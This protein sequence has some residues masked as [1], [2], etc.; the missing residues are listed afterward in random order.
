MKKT[1]DETLLGLCKSLDEEPWMALTALADRLEEL[2]DNTRACGI[3]WLVRNRR[4]PDPCLEHC[5][6]QPTGTH[7]LEPAGCR[8]SWFDTELKAARYGP[9][10]YEFKNFYTNTAYKVPFV[11]NISKRKRKR[12]FKTASEAYLYAGLVVGEFLEA[13][14]KG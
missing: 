10:G 9:Q 1:T 7:W 2:G 12:K 8:W 4:S 13:A 6:S 3:R 11:P 14:P 5:F